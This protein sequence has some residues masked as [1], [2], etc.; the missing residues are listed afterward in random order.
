MADGIQAQVTV[1]WS[2]PSATDV[3]V[4]LDGASPP[5]GIQDTAPY[6]VPAG[7]APGVGSTIV[8]PC[9]AD[10]HTSPMLISSGWS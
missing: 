1:G 6:Q 3:T 5:V 8:F 4:L 10:A 2:V 7:K 9:A